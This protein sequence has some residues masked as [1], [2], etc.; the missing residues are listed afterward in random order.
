MYCGLNWRGTWTWDFSYIF[1][2]VSFEVEGN[3]L[4]DTEKKG[5]SKYVVPDFVIPN[6][7]KRNKL[8]PKLNPQLSNTRS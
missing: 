7:I 1:G 6:Y 2:Y 3:L 8:T 4:I 5:C